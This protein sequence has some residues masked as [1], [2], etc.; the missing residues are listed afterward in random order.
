MELVVSKPSIRTLVH[1]KAA[2]LKDAVA[3]ESVGRKDTVC[4]E[5]GHYAIMGFEPALITSEYYKLRYLNDC[6]DT[7]GVYYPDCP[8][9]TV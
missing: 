5:L 8:H 4:S 3:I 9:P 6:Q 2:V 1:E 7:F